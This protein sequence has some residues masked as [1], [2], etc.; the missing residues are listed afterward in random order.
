[1]EKPEG[2]PYHIGCRVVITN[3]WKGRTVYACVTAADP[4][5]SDSF[6]L[7]LCKAVPE[8]IAVEPEKQAS[9]KI[10]SYGS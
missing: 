9:E 4:E 7:F 1:M 8:R 5:I 3:L 2:A 6:H 10:C